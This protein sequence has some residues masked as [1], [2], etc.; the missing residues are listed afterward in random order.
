MPQH[1][2]QPLAARNPAFAEHFVFTRGHRPVQPGA[3]VRPA[4]ALWIVFLIAMLCGQTWGW[5][6][7]AAVAIASLWYLPL[8]TILSLLYLGLLYF[9]KVRAVGG[10]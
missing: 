5:Y 6:G 4:G 9:G 1:P 8:G 10:A 3:G 2:T 7:A